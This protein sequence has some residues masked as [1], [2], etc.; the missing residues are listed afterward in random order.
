MGCWRRRCVAATATP[1]LCPL[2]GTNGVE[3]WPSALHGARLVPVGTTT[4]TTLSGALHGKMLWTGSQWSRGFLTEKR[5][6][7]PRRRARRG[8]SVEPLHSAVVAVQGGLGVA[9][10]PGRGGHEQLLPGGQRR[11]AEQGA[12]S[13]LLRADN[14][15]D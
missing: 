11:R 8:A 5:G 14:P 2:A 7:S 3:G 1:L 10:R 13:L 15:H 6:R 9:D 12:A 4:V